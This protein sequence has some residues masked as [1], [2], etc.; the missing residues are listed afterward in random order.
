M[1]F[2]IVI[3]YT[4]RTSRTG[5]DNLFTK[6]DKDSAGHAPTFFVPMKM[7]GSKRW[8]AEFSPSASPQTHLRWI[9]VTLYLN[10]RNISVPT[11][12]TYAFAPTPTIWLRAKVAMTRIKY[13]TNIYSPGQWHW[14]WRVWHWGQEMTLR[15]R[16]DNEG[17]RWHWG[18]EMTLRTRDDNEGK[19]WQWGQEMTLRTRDNNEGKRWQWGQKMTLRTRD[20]NEGKRWQWGQGMTRRTRDDTEDKRWHWGQ[21]MTMRARD[22][23]EDKRWHWGQEKT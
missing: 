19:R 1:A 2:N 9:I 13:F 18:Q 14:Q 6:I 11:V 20:D 3:L 7:C 22:D 17:K 5:N 8:R 10:S 21:G 4:I 23:T 16:D 12:S 15:T